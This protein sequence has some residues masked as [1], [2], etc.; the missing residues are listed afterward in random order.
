MDS[1]VQNTAD[2]DDD[3]DDDQYYATGVRFVRVCVFH[4][5]VFANIETFRPAVAEQTE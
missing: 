5:K 1:V 3:N 2:L 4:D